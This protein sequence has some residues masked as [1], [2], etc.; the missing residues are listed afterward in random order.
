MS[1]G[2]EQALFNIALRIAMQAHDGQVDRAGQPYITHP[3]RMASRTQDPDERVV[4]ILHD[5]VE[6]GL[7]NDVTFATLREAGFPPHILEAVD[8]LTRRRRETFPNLDSDEPYEDF[9]ERSTGSPLSRAVKL[10]DLQDNMD[11]TRLP[12]VKESDLERLNRYLKAWRRL[13]EGP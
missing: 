8:N 1:T 13:K 3:L 12:K 4:A 5:A 7:E 11:I 9:V 6:D 2:D 10:L